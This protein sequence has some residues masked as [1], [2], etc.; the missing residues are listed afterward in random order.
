MHFRDSNFSGRYPRNHNSY[1]LWTKSFSLYCWIKMV[2]QA[3]TCTNERQSN[4]WPILS[5]Q[6]RYMYLYLDDL[7]NLCLSGYKSFS[8]TFAGYMSV[9]I[10]DVHCWNLHH[11][12]DYCITGLI[13]VMNL[14][15]CHPYW[16]HLCK[17][18]DSFIIWHACEVS[19]H[20]TLI[21]M[22]EKM[23]SCKIYSN[24]NYSNISQ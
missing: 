13:I 2:L 3:A 23:C 8:Y 18:Y 12:F 15:I 19:P 14:R 7:V 4:T 20:D 17:F 6:S 21:L 24:Y 22:K 11:V 1:G 10:Y 5:I 9:W 16:L